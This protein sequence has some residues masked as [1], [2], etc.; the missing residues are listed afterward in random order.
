MNSKQALDGNF[1][2]CDRVLPLVLK[3]DDIA[4]ACYNP[5]YVL[6]FHQAALDIK[7]SNC[8]RSS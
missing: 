7:E 6:A 4:P 2:D 8:S 5:E 3:D 1:P